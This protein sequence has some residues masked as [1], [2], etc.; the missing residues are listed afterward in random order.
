MKA[1]AWR[2]NYRTEVRNV[3]HREPHDEEAVI[4]TEEAAEEIAEEE[5]KEAETVI[6]EVAEPVQKASEV[7]EPEPEKPVYLSEEDYLNRINGK[8]WEANGK[9]W[10]YIEVNAWDLLNEAE[11]GAD[12][13]KTVVSAVRE[14]MLEGDQYLNDSDSGD[15]TVRYYCDNLSP[16]RR[17]YSEVNQ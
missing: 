16:E 12:N 9:G 14:A 17:K 3:R 11:P 5:L 8:K 1:N 13:M 10:L 4:E 2:K 15:L 6:P 7:R